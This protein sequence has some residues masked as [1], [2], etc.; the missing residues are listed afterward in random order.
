M[1]DD[2]KINLMPENLRGKEEALKSKAGLH[3]SPDLSLPGRTYSPVKSKLSGSN[4]S[5]WEKLASVFKPKTKN[6][7]DNSR[8]ASSHVNTA[9]QASGF[10]IPKLQSPIMTA[11]ADNFK[12]PV[13]GGE[14]RSGVLPSKKEEESG[15]GPSFWQRLAKFFQGKP[16]TT[17]PPKIKSKD[18][19]SILA[20]SVKKNG[21]S[22]IGS[23]VEVRTPQVEPKPQIFQN[24]NQPIVPEK[25]VEDILEPKTIVEEKTFVPVP[26][27]KFEPPVEPKLVSPVSPVLEPSQNNFVIPEVPVFRENKTTPAPAEAVSS[28][29]HQPT[30]RIKGRLLE[31]GSGVDLIPTAA[32][33]RSWLQIGGLMF[34][35]I[36]ASVVILGLFYGVLYWQEQDIAHKQKIQQDKITEIEKNIL[37]FT[38]LNKNISDL[39]KEIKLV[40]ETLNKHI[41]WTNFFSLLEKYTLPDVSYQGLSAGNNGALSLSATASSY[42]SVAKQLKILEDSSAREFVSSVKINS[43]RQED[44][45]GVTFGINLV[46]NPKLF[47]YSK[48]ADSN[49]Q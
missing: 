24:L 8:V 10:E 39:G 31:N 7:M 36:L 20:S 5:F 21:L 27:I 42:D 47:Y 19:S 40:Q 41:Y 25:K 45:R 1:A 12:S 6:I 22:N 26:E 30:P 17:R 44:N 37:N 33:V 18:N 46:L 48:P 28:K 2:K 43:A 32:R 11:Q 35:S 4:V 13:I 23:D 16:K 9:G 49:G 34:L 38:E 29:F 14:K 15:S 3:L